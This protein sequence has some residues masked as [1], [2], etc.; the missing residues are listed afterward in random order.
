MSFTI[1]DLNRDEVFDNN[2]T[3]ENLDT[4]LI[5]EIYNEGTGLGGYNVEDKNYKKPSADKDDE[6]ASAD[7]DDEQASADEDDEQA[8]ADKEADE[9]DD[10]PSADEDRNVNLFKLILIKILKNILKKL[11]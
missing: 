9:D 4:D 1:E 2:D 5:D 3:I 8:S 10:Q 7:E 6:Q 11:N